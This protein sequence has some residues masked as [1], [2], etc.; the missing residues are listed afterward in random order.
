M[1]NLNRI[2]LLQDRIL[3]R[4]AGKH[5]V[6]EL[7]NDSARTNSQTL[8]QLRHAETRAELFLLAVDL[9][10]HII[11]KTVSDS[12]TT[13]GQG[14]RFQVRPIATRKRDRDSHA[15]LRRHYPDQVRGVTRQL[16]PRVLSPPLADTPSIKRQLTDGQEQV[17]PEWIRSEMPTAEKI[18]QSSTAT[19]A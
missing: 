18:L 8:K 14:I 11:K 6:V 16:T 4:I 12:T 13:R 9:D 5:I 19:L 2:P 17:K 1:N 10:N 7:N 15:S 3:E